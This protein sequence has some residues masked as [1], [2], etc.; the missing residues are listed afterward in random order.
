MLRIYFNL[1]GRSTVQ[2]A[3]LH[4]TVQNENSCYLT[5][6]KKLGKDA[7]VIE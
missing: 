3:R 6:L 7:R 1:Q 5:G 2:E 4:V